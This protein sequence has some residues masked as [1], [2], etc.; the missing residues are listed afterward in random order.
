MLGVGLSIAASFGWITQ[1]DNFSVG[2]VQ[3][4]LQD[5]L[6]V[7]AVETAAGAQQRSGGQA[8]PCM[9]MQATRTQ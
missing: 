2:Q 9:Q 7:S 8:M 5:F 3:V 4:G 1:T 6:V